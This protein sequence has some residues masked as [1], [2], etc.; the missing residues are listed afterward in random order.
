MRLSNSAPVSP[1][2]EHIEMTARM[3]QSRRDGAEHHRDRSACAVPPRSENVDATATPVL[4]E[5]SCVP[6]RGGSR[7]LTADESCALGA[8]VTGWAIVENHHLEQTFTFR[9]FASAFAF[10]KAVAQIAEAQGHHP[11]V[12]LAWGRARV[13]IWTHKIDGLSENDFILA[14]RIDRSAR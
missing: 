10:V 14:A 5:R 9:D 13:R 1:C 8:Q 11:E 3:D 4:A 12:L 6:C 7:A 2:G